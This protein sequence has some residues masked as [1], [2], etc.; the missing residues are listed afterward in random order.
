MKV[1]GI[2]IYKL[3][4]VILKYAKQCTKQV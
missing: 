4:N 1:L 2:F 3:E